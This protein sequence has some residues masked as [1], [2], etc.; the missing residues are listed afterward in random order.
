MAYQT[1][2]EDVED[3]IAEFS[4][5]A[6]V[7]PVKPLSGFKVLLPGSTDELRR[8]IWEHRADF[9]LLIQEWIPGGDENIYFCALHLD[10]GEVLASFTGR[11]LRSRP[12]ALGGTT[13]AV[14]SSHPT[15]RAM[16][17]AF[18]SAVKRAILA[19]SSL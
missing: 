17:E 12:R 13:M 2:R 1:V 8:A 4:L 9:P 6:I 7:K 10:H 5:P 11:K 15:P 18:F 3:A 16:A 19:S 14:S